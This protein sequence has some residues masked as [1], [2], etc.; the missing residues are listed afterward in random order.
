MNLF[1]IHH[2]E[3]G[4]SQSLSPLNTTHLLASVISTPFT[5][6]L[7][8]CT[9]NLNI[10]PSGISEFHNGWLLKSYVS[11]C[12]Y[13][14]CYVFK[15]S[16]TSV[17]HSSNIPDKSCRPSLCQYIVLYLPAPPN[18]INLLISVLFQLMWDALSPSF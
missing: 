12:H 17:F 3:N 16:Q 13:V 7:G 8:S 1:I 9:S 10:S 5:F 18:Y 14:S 6:S 15:G 2:E 4:N 11:K